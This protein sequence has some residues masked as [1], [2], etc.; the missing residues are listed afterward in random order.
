M[1]TWRHGGLTH[2][3]VPTHVPSHPPQAYKDAAELAAE[4]GEGE[5]QPR[6]PKW[7]VF[8]AMVGGP[9]LRVGVGWEARR[10]GLEF[11]SVQRGPGSTAS[12]P[13]HAPLSPARPL[14][15]ESWLG[16]SEG[17]PRPEVR[18]YE[19]E[20]DGAARVLCARCYSLRHYG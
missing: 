7:D 11:G 2:T 9:H 20:D 13:R 16:G 15:V 17:A 5:E 12:R 8:D 10:E 4:G 3:P 1:A 14:Q 19:E 6:D 18:S